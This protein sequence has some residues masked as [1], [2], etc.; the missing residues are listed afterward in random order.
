M[1]SHLDGFTTCR[2]CV[3]NDFF[4]SSAQEYFVLPVYYEAINKRKTGVRWGYI[5]FKFFINLP[6]DD[7]TSSS[8]FCAVNELYAGMYIGASAGMSVEI[9][10]IQKT[11]GDR[12]AECV[13]LRGEQQLTAKYGGCKRYSWLDNQCF[14]CANSPVRS[15]DAPVQYM[16]T[17]QLTVYLFEVWKLMLRS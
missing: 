17:E 8:A 11:P 16:T 12:K 10:F 13:S 4:K 9:G 3:L 14:A 1:T 2:L 7:V 15:M 6:F 5:Y